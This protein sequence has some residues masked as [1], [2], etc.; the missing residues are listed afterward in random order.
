MTIKRFVLTL[1]LGIF[2]AASAT[3]QSYTYNY[4]EMKMDE[5]NL[6]LQEWQEKET[7]SKSEIEN[8]KTKITELNTKLEGL[9]SQEK[10]TWNE[11]YALVGTD[12]AGFKSFM[13]ELNSLSNDVSGLLSS[14]PDDI[15]RRMN[16]L[17]EYQ[18]KVGELKADKRALLTE[19]M[20]KISSIEGMLSQAIEKAKSANATYIVNRGD[21]LWGIA[22]NPDVYG[23]AFAWIRLWTANRNI[24]KN[25][26]LIYPEQVLQ[27]HRVSGP[28]EYVVK[29]GEFLYKIAKESLG[30]PFKWQQLYEANKGVI[31]ED[32]TR[33]YPH[34]I[35]RMP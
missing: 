28:G 24:I 17:K 30:N 1:I 26:D 23:D 16:E 9:K 19:S 4:E 20:N 32:P 10:S 34:M 21:Y 8:E 7:A 6:K 11:I 33:I 29:R 31:G 2:L 13:T 35:L 3:A 27:V 25:P 22:K 12:E 14:S 18:A 5:Y 15:F